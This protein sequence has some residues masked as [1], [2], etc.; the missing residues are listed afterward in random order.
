MNE[1]QVKFEFVVIGAGWE[2]Y[3]LFVDGKE[4]YLI[5]TGISTNYDLNNL[6]EALCCFSTNYN[7]YDNT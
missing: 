5:S 2:D 6:L 4:I 7:R 1:S 3:R